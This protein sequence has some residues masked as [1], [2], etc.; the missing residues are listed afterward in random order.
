MVDVLYTNLWAKFLE[1]K[2]G[3]K[4]FFRWAVG[5]WL[6]FIVLDVVTFI[7]GNGLLPTSILAVDIFFLTVF[8]II[9][10]VGHHAFKD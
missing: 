2:N 9:L 4:I 5:V 7:I 3:D 6:A 8:L 1:I 10:L